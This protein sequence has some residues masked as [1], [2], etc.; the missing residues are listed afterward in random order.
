M[1]TLESLSPSQQYDLTEEVRIKRD[2][3]L[4]DYV[5]RKNYIA[6]MRKQIKG[7]AAYI[8]L[9]DSE[10]RTRDKVKIR[11]AFR[12]LEQM[13]QFMGNNIPMVNMHVP[14]T[15]AIDPSVIFSCQAQENFIRT[16]MKEIEFGSEYAMGGKT[17]SW[18]GGAAYRLYDVQGIAKFEA[19]ERP[20]N[21]ILCYKQDDFS[22]LEAYIYE[23]SMSPY[24]VKRKWDIDID[25]EAEVSAKPKHTQSEIPEYAS[26]WTRAGRQTTGSYNLQSPVKYSDTPKG[27]VNIQR[28]EDDEKELTVVK[29]HLVEYKE[30]NY[31]FVPLYIFRN[32]VIP[33]E[34]WGVSDYYAAEDLEKLV[35]G[36]LDKENTAVNE[37]MMKTYTT[38]SMKLKKED[39]QMDEQT[40][41]RLIRLNSTLGETF[42]DATSS[43]K[44]DTTQIS[45]ERELLELMMNN[46]SFSPQQMLSAT[47]A[48]STTGKGIRMAFS[49]VIGLVKS[50]QQQMS[51]QLELWLIVDLSRLKDSFLRELLA[52]LT[53]SLVMFLRK[54]LR[55]TLPP[56]LLNRTQVF[57]RNI[58]HARSWVCMTR[59]LK[60]L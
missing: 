5:K 7:D 42:T 33:G 44:I 48:N 37:N 55:Q 47:D 34:P 16:W 10:G 24:A 11:Y 43:S 40:R 6:D 2:M 41:S 51:P 39:L 28:Y 3:W 58:P 52:R 49:S 60:N 13:S 46:M 26:S 23:Y 27:F 9:K 12:I 20:E 36:Y 15:Y 21:L 17:A 50:K 30:K 4:A 53:L 29:G 35:L 56:M 14:P 8:E 25:P 59:T 31:G 57:F 54:I 45:G 18:F 19:I 22:E 32:I 1:A 38:N